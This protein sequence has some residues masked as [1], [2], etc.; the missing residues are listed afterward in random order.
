MQKNDNKNIILTGFMGTGKTT[1][2][3]LLA[4][5][6][7]RDFIDT[8]KLIEDRQGITIPEIFT[9]LGESAFR[10]MEADIARELGEREGLVISTGGRLM[11][12]PA[13]VAALSGRGRVFCLVATPEEILS[14]LKNDKDNRRPLLD[15]PNPGEHIVKLLQERK[16][17]YQRFL[18]LATGDK[19]PADVTEKLL[20]FIQRSPGYFTIDS[21]AQSY[22]FIVGNG[23]LPFT[24]ELA[25]TDG[26]VVIIT[27]TVVGK[28]YAQSCGSV[29]HVI[30][31]P[32]GSQQKTLTAVQTICDQLLDTG[33]DESGTIIALGGRKVCDISGFV[34]GTFMR[35]V[36]LV[37]CPTSL[38]AMIDII[39]GGKSSADLPQDKNLMDTFKQPSMVIADVVTLT[40]LPAEDLLSGMAEVT[41][42]RL[43]ADDAP[44]KDILNILQALSSP[45]VAAAK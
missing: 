12:D 11:L 41:K 9:D 45:V 30:T 4:R 39:V 32:P 24:C 14:R 27:D 2:G 18:K 6:L 40:T 26:M 28:L 36:R 22:E 15:V 8:D 13:N 7:K 33:F 35:G 31:I 43:R 1:V 17:G 5:K 29:D 23:I 21:P 16:T 19:Q 20:D 37:Q 3:K 10:Q 42:Y 38:P 25:G 34:V 44:T